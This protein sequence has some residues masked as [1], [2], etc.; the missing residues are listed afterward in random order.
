MIIKFSFTGTNQTLGYYTFTKCSRISGS[1]QNWTKI[2]LNVCIFIFKR[3]EAFLLSPLFKTRKRENIMRVS[4]TQS[5]TVFSL[6]NIIN[7]TH[8]VPYIIYKM[9][10]YE[11][12]ERIFFS[13]FN[14]FVIYLVTGWLG[15]VS[16]HRHYSICS[17]MGYLFTILVVRIFVFKISKHTAVCY[18]IHFS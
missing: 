6:N 3:D 14:V 18:S 10:S 13:L 8:N 16:L 12:M 9:K 5:R 1:I 2:N 17:R 11:R 7:M 4:R 15:Y